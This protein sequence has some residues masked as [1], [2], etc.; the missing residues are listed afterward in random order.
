MSTGIGAPSSNS[1]LQ[2]VNLT[3]KDKAKA[4]ANKLNSHKV[5]KKI[6]NQPP[7]LRRQC[8]INYRLLTGLRFI[9]NVKSLNFNVFSFW[10]PTT[11]E[12]LC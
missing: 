6:S 10:I 2:T 5:Q 12:R 7:V 9:T 4:K 8:G 1:P 3:L 11:T